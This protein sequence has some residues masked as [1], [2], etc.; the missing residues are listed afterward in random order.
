MEA[1]NELGNYQGVRLRN[2]SAVAFAVLAEYGFQ[3]RDSR[4]NTWQGASVVA[5]NDTVAIVVDA[6]WSERELS[7]SIQVTGAQPLPVERLIPELR[8]VTRLLPRNAGRGVLQRRL[9][10]IVEALLSEAPDVLQGGHQAL[11]RV[12]KAG[13]APT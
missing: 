11:M 10:L 5:A 3:L 12:V 6:D 7:V 4:L 8:H 1:I 9:N 13:A 2:A